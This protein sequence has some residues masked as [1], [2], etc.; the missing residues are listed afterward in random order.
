MIRFDCHACGRRIKVGDDRAGQR[1]RCPKCGA[2]VL[3]PPPQIAESPSKSA[4]SSATSRRSAL[5]PLGP[6]RPDVEELI[7]M[8]AMVDIVFFLLIFFMVASLTAR[9]SSIELP[10]P[11]PQDQA[12]S[13][14]RARTME[15]F[16]SD[17]EFLILR[18]AG[19]NTLW[20][21]DSQVLDPAKLAV[22]LHDEV[23]GRGASPGG[24]TKLL[25]AADGD[26]HHGLVVSAIDAGHE[27]GM[28][29]VRFA[30]EEE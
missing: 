26:A 22:R 20:I 3:V 1:G 7:D 19:D 9:Q 2:A 23:E 12:A 16:E 4:G 30:V 24:A 6:K 10:T 21:E 29:D 15:D 14:A 5:I 8:T 27:A 11:A 13:L 17:A 28:E 18:I 25:V